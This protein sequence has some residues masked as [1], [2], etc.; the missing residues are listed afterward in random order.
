MK[1]HSINK[2]TKTNLIFGVFVTALTVFT[3]NQA[4]S[5][6]LTVLKTKENAKSGFINNENFGSKHLES[7]SKSCKLKTVVMNEEQL[8]TLEEAKLVKKIA[9]IKKRAQKKS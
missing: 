9:S 7:L 1:A 4:F 8:I 5:C 3:I 6:E 2:I